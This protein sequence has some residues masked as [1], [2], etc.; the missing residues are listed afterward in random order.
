[1]PAGW[2][3]YPV[4]GRIRDGVFCHQHPDRQYLISKDVTPC[5]GTRRV[6]EGA[7]GTL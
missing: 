2:R 7:V 1:M 6:N 4:G 3:V 5:R